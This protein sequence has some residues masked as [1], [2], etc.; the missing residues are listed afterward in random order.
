MED[1]IDS[2]KLAKLMF[3]HFQVYF[4]SLKLDFYNSVTLKK[5]QNVYYFADDL[6]ER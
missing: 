6:H 4:S 3:K 2:W 5:A 1:D